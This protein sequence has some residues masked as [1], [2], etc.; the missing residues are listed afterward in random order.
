M[1]KWPIMRLC[2]KNDKCAQLK[3]GFLF[4]HEKLSLECNYHFH[5]EKLLLACCVYITMPIPF[6]V[7]EYGEGRTDCYRLMTKCGQWTWAK[8][9]SYIVFNH[10][11]S[12][13]EIYCSTTKMIRYS[14]HQAFFCSQMLGITPNLH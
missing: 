9:R 1:V 10:W 2:L 4:Y 13:P 3:I 5:C 8:S 12:K 11:N 14:V 7:M 6:A